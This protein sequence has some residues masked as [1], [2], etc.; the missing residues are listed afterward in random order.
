METRRGLALGLMLGLSGCYVRYVS[1]PPPEP[2]PAPPESS[3]PYSSRPESPSPP[4]EPGECGAPIRG[5]N[6][7]AHPGA[8]VLFADLLGTEEIPQFAAEAGCQ[9]AVTGIQVFIGLEIPR[10]EQPALEAFME[11]PG[12]E[13]DRARLLEREFWRRAHQ[14]G[15]SSAAVLELIEYARELKSNGRPVALFAYDESMAQGPERDSAMARNISAWREYAPNAL[16]LVLSGSAH[17]RAGRPRSWDDGMPMAAHL[18]RSERWLVA[19]TPA[20]EGG[21][22]W[23]CQGPGAEKIH[24]G[25]HPVYGRYPLPRH[26]TYLPGPSDSRPQHQR[27]VT[28]WPRPSPDGFQG[29]FYVGTVTASPPAVEPGK[30]NPKEQAWIPDRPASERSPWSLGNVTA[31]QK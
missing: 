1:A 27:F 6:A 5:L 26:H 15:R 28:L 22:A 14:D 8:M 30:K 13:D 25:A 31:D 4:K 12:K 16:F 29:V 19:L 11:S 21:M 17:A 10:E 20:Y 7:V 3:G 2:P 24:C 23:N 9:Q 18:R